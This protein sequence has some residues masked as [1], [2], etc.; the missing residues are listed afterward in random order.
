MYVFQSNTR[1]RR[2]HDQAGL[3]VMRETGQVPPLPK[4]RRP[5]L[6]LVRVE[7]V[8]SALVSRR[9]PDSGGTG[10]ALVNIAR[11]VASASVPANR[12]SKFARCHRDSGRVARC[13]V[14]GLY[15]DEHRR[16]W[17]LGFPNRNRVSRSECKLLYGQVV[18]DWSW[19][20]PPTT[21][22]TRRTYLLCGIS[23]SVRNC[24]RAIGSSETT[25]RLLVLLLVDY[26]IHSTLLN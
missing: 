12:T 23:E 8:P 16:E 1:Q 4:I 14:L 11:P 17:R 22:Y 9:L 20:D 26:F 24:G 3:S 18:G 25:L 10:T 2:R 19:Q 7:A 21:S 13:S 15:R 5:L 6:P